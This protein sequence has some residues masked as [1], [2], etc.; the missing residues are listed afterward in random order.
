MTAILFIIFQI[1]YGDV[2]AA[3]SFDN[4]TP[5]PTSRRNMGDHQGQILVLLLLFI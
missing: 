3:G 4:Y 1:K 2:T 5:L